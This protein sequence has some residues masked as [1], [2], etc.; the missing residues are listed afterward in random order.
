MRFTLEIFS[1]I[2]KLI[3]F[4]TA[5]LT[6]LTIFFIKQIFFFLVG[7]FKVLFASTNTKV[8]A[9]VLVLVAVL[10][11]SIIYRVTNQYTY[12]P[13]INLLVILSPFFYIASVGKRSGLHEKGVYVN[14]K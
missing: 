3:G 6:Q 8:T 1:L 10:D 14:D 9:S 5:I 7:C 13:Y 4:I 11:A 2:A 12:S